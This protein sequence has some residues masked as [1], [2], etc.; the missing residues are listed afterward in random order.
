MDLKYFQMLEF[1]NNRLRNIE[2]SITRIDEKL[3]YTIALHRNYFIRIKHGEDLDDNMI[4]MG[5]PYNDLSPQKA[6]EIYCNPDMDFVILDVSRKNFKPQ[7]QLR[8]SV[9]IPLEELGR[10]YVEL[11]NRTVPILVISEQGLRSIQACELLVKKGYFNLNNISGG[12]RYW[13]G[14]PRSAELS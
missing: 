10:R 11:A 5:R 12:Y 1:I 9:S 4:L 13:P 8:G 3:D 2:A 14:Y 6:Y 7:S